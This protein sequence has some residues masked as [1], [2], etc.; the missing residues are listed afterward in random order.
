MAVRA[1][2]TGRNRR[3][4]ERLRTLRVIVVPGRGD[5]VIFRR[6]TALASGELPS[7]RAFRDRR[8]CV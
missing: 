1:C 6:A 8:P 3:G 5:A 4:V 2:V 7:S